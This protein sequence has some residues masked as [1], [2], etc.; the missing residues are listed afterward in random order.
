MA[1]IAQDDRDH[2]PNVGFVVDDEDVGH[3]IVPGAGLAVGKE[4]LAHEWNPS[5]VVRAGTKRTPANA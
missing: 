2:D 5:G 1:R 3:R 4:N